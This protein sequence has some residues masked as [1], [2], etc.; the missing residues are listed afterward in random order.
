MDRL[1]RIRLAQG[2]LVSALALSLGL[3]LASFWW[4]D[5]P[6]GAQIG[7]S[8]YLILALGFGSWVNW[9][10]P[11]PLPEPPP[12][13][14][15]FRTGLQNTSRREWLLLLLSVSL[16]LYAF[17]LQILSLATPIFAAESVHNLA[18]LRAWSAMGIAFCCSQ[19]MTL[20][21]RMRDNAEQSS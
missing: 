5:V 21:K 15:S 4:T 6:D 2:L 11:R 20:G 3:H 14:V 16:F 8:F 10:I 7:L 13:R 18:S 9:T 17:A 19:L 1:T 12:P